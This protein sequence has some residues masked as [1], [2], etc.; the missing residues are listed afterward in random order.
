MLGPPERPAALVRTSRAQLVAVSDGYRFTAAA[1]GMAM[2]VLPVQFSHCWKIENAR[3][4]NAQRILRAN[5]VQTAIL[6]KDNVDVRLRFDFEKDMKLAAF[7][8]LWTLHRLSRSLS[9]ASRSIRSSAGQRVEFMDERQIAIEVSALAMRRGRCAQARSINA[10]SY[11]LEFRVFYAAGLKCR[12]ADGR[13]GQVVDE[14]AEREI[15]TQDDE[16]LVNHS[17]VPTTRY[18]PRSI[19]AASMPP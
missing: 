12:W 18:S 5:V 4:I 6:F 17:V 19:A 15:G 14:I 10:A 1:P 13:G 16:R 7:S 11:R 3:D 2:V 9:S 8:E